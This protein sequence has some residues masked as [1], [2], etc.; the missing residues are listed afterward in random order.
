MEQRVNFV[1]FATVDL[2]AARSFYQQGLGW[3]PLLDVPDEIVFFQ[4]GPGLVL[5]LFEAVKFAADL[6]R[7]ASGTSIS[8]VTLSVNVDGPEAVDEVFQSATAAGA[9]IVKAPVQ[10]SFGGYHG[11]FQDPNGIIWEI[12]HNPGWSVD[13]AGTVSLS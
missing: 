6:N 2:D 3:Q 10:A 4:I 7:E 12:A 9:T 5:G 11:H 13:E 8:G 1:T